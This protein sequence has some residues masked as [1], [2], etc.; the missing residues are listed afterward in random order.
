MFAL[1]LGATITLESL[2]LTKMIQDWGSPG[3]AKSVDG[4]PLTIGGTVYTHGVGTHASSDFIINL[5][6]GAKGFT[7]KV[8]VDDETKG[9]G[10]VRFEVFVDGRKAAD[11]GIVRTGERSRNIAVSLAGARKLELVVEPGASGKGGQ[12][13]VAKFLQPK[14]R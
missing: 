14:L 9:R 12:D 7:A 5:R 11:S 3:V 1:L 10:S 6:S 2:D 8:G 4:H 13:R